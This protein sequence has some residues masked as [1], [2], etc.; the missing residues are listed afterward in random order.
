[1]KRIILSAI[2][3]ISMGW[4]FSTSCVKKDFDAPPDS[5][6]Y[7]PKLTVNATIWKLK[8][9]YYSNLSPT[10]IDSDWTIA[11]LVV[12][13]D[14][15]GNFY[16]QIVVQDSTSGITV[17]IGKSSGLYSDYP[18]GRK[19][20]IKCKGLY[21][22]AYGGFIQLGGQP[23]DGTSDLTDIPTA[24]VGRYIVKANYPNPIVPKVVTL[25]DIKFTNAASQTDA[26]RRMLG[27]LI[28]IDSAEF[29]QDEVGLDYALDPNLSSGTDRNIED[30][31]G[32]KMV[33]RN[34]GY[35]KFRTAKLPAGK[36]RVWAIYSTYESGSKKTPQ[37]LLRDTTDLQLTGT[38]CGGIVILP[39][40]R[41][42]IDSIRKM[43]TS[44]DIKLGNYKIRG[45]VTTSVADSNISSGN[46][47]I[48]D[49]SN[50]GIAVYFGSTSHNMKLG[51]S[52]EVNVSGDSL[53]VYRG[54]L[55]IKAST[56]QIT[57][58]SSGASVTPIVVTLA[59]LNA[60]LN[61][62]VYNQRQYEGVLVKINNCTISGTPATYSGPLVADR[63]K[64]I[65][66]ATGTITM[67][68]LSKIPYTTTNYPTTPVSITAVAT[69]FNTTN[70]IQI[71]KLSDVQ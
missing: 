5:S 55:E 52:I 3:L 39:A 41:V 11:G 66:D 10:L 71:R 17:L 67:Y 9:L 38:R 7:D 20:Y 2:T 63:S 15:S 13:D 47:Y 18:I 1:M 53:I 60:D 16:K 25:A 61:N 8:Q 46:L 23:I 21:L 35:A 12:A 68:T 26:Q 51:D 36:G 59:N 62:A 40:E 45:V 58:I 69:R 6:G 43:Y 42:T 34:S 56:S 30:C 29:I 32:T 57:K 50:R 27:T 24:S 14:R 33:V 4:I 37:L 28:Q 49:E 19:I 70:Q 22:G 65:T 54:T 44:N 64:T 48:Q 31:A